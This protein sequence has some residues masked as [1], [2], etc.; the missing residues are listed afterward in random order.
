MDGGAPG[1]R[2][3]LQAC[4]LSHG[5]NDVCAAETVIAGPITV[6]FQGETYVRLLDKLLGIDN[7]SLERKAVHVDRRVPNR[8]KLNLDK[9][10]AFFY[11]YRGYDS[12]VKFL[13]ALELK[14]LVEVIMPKLPSSVEMYN[15]P[16][17][18][19]QIRWY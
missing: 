16:V 15:G 12:K 19:A 18:S 2:W 8:T 7:S 9:D 3:K 14:R 10:E 13:S 11:G 6:T 5:P 4:R 1:Q 17:E